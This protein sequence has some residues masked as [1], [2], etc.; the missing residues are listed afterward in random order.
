MFRIL[1]LHTFFVRSMRFFLEIPK[2]P[3]HYGKSEG[4]NDTPKTETEKAQKG[5]FR[6]VQCFIAFFEGRDLN[7]RYLSLIFFA[8]PFWKGQ[9]KPTKF[10]TLVRGIS[11]SW[12]VLTQDPSVLK[13]DGESPFSVRGVE[14]ATGA[15][16]THT[17]SRRE[18][19]CFDLGK[20]GRSKRYR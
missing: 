10:L 19:I 14:F 1:V 6:E 9:G 12:S 20:R 18:V 17:E 2:C 13:Y 4:R 3:C 11:S 5:G 8:L 16:N 15:A 7:A